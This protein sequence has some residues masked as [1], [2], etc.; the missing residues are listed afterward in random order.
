MSTEDHFSSVSPF[1]YRVCILT[2]RKYTLAEC[3]KDAR[4]E[5]KAIFDVDSLST[6]EA[7]YL[8]DC[9]I[10]VAS[11]VEQQLK[12]YDQGKLRASTIP[13]VGMESAWLW[14]HECYNVDILTIRSMTEQYGC[15]CP[16]F[17]KWLE[18]ERE[19]RHFL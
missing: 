17:Y 13:T 2:T 5:L 15:A 9:V 1:S 4:F 18:R 12:E 14:V 10:R 7:W 3:I 6:I 8:K 11:L 19:K 16:L